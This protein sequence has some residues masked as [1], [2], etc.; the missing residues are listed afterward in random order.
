MDYNRCCIPRLHS[1]KLFKLSTNN[2]FEDCTNSQWT[3]DL[4]T[5]EFPSP[6]SYSTHPQTHQTLALTTPTTLSHP[7]HSHTFTPATPSQP[8]QIHTPSTL[9]IDHTSSISQPEMEWGWWRRRGGGLRWRKED[10]LVMEMV[11]VWTVERVRVVMR[12]GGS[13][14]K[15]GWSVMEKDRQ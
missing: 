8:R 10:R 11:Y 1:W 13:G 6:L 4:L 7:S 9:S 2:Y 12:W 3:N 15:G 5:A 14:E